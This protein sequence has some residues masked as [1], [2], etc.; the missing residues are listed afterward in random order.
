MKRRA[1][2]RTQ[3]IDQVPTGWVIYI[4]ECGDKTLYTGITNDFPRR[5]MAHQTGK[6]ARYTRSRG[7]LR[8]V[9]FETAESKSIALKREAAI[10]RLSR[11]AKVN[12]IRKDV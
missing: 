7:P 10:K 4:L 11:D 5:F 8:C 9:Y 1:K 3:P 2:L 6:G 12:L